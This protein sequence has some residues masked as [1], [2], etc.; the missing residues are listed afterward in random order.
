MLRKLYGA[1]CTRH[2]PLAP[3]YSLP[4]NSYLLLYSTGYSLEGYHFTTLHPFCLSFS[5]LDFFFQGKKNP[6]Q[7]FSEFSYL[8]NNSAHF[9]LF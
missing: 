2:H 9:S 6:S 3:S 7:D 5:L 1:S 4:R 8:V